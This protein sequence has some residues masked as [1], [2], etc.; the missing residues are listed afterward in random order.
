MTTQ[1]TKNYL[2]LMTLDNVNEYLIKVIESIGSTR[3]VDISQGLILLRVNN[4]L[5]PN[6]IENNMSCTSCR[7][8][9]YNRMKAYYD[10]IK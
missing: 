8:R 6:I 10:S 1:E 7:I 3:K 9:V 2:K 4:M 5:Y